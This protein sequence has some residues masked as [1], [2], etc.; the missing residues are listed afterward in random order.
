MN[1]VLFII[2]IIIL[3]L[4]LLL[5]Y[6]KY[7]KEGLSYF[8]FILAIL[9]SIILLKTVDIITFEVN[10]GLVFNILIFIGFNIIVQKHG[11]RETNKLMMM[12]FLGLIIGVIFLIIFSNLEGSNFNLLTNKSYDY[13]FGNA[14]RIVIAGTLSLMGALSFNSILYYELRKIKNKIYIS[15]ILSTIIS[16]FIEC[17]LFI[18]IAYL[19]KVNLSYMLKLIVGRYILKAV[20]GLIGTSVIYIAYRVKED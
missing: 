6:K 5:I 17:T 8:I 18:T 3:Y 10:L 12:I 4:S 7:K 1:N 19:F 15:N 11:P 9:S 13:V 16:Q 14:L 20:I 2:K